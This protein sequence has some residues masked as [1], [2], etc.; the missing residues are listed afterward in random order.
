MLLV[1]PIFHVAARAV[2]LRAAGPELVSLDEE[3]LLCLW[4]R[5]RNAVP[6]ETRPV[7]PWW[8]G[9]LHFSRD[10]FG[11]DGEEQL[12]FGEAAAAPEEK[13][14]EEDEG[15]STRRGD[16]PPPP[17]SPRSRRAPSRAQPREADDGWHTLAGL[18]FPPLDRL[19]LADEQGRTE[20]QATFVPCGA[21]RP[22][23]AGQHVWRHVVEYAVD[24]RRITL[25]RHTRIRCTRK[26]EAGRL[27]HAALTRA[28]SELLVLVEFP[29]PGRGA[30]RSPARPVRPPARGVR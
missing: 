15:L 22:A 28:R 9:R 23:L 20:V 2:G 17:P 14:D 11:N 21:R 25:L 4:S 6:V 3:G 5:G 30:C 1:A 18:E 12:L 27:V 7:A 29:A 8:E 24:A 16:T 10:L 13:G 26:T 19:V